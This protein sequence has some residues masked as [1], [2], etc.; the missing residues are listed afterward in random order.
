M[1]QSHDEIREFLDTAITKWRYHLQNVGTHLEK[2][3]KH[4]CRCYI[5]A[6][7]SVRVSIFDELL[8]IDTETPS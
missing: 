6:F 4:T 7:Q 5:D 3:D 8:P 2:Y 1:L